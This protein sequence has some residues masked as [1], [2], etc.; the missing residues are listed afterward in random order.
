[1]ACVVAALGADAESGGGEE[2]VD[3]FAFAFVAPLGAED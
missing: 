2:D 3:E 1:M